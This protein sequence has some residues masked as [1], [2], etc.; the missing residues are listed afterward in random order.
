MFSLIGTHFVDLV[1]VG[2]SLFV[3]TLLAVSVT[4]NLRQRGASVQDR[5]SAPREKV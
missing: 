3:I 2:M 1:I 4:E 5:I